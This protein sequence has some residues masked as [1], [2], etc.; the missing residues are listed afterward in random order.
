[1]SALDISRVEPPES[2]EPLY[3]LQLCGELFYTAFQ[4]SVYFGF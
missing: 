3:T 4:A 2:R 1:M